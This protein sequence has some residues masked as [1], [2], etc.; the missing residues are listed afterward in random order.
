MTPPLS[1][2]ALCQALDVSRETEARLALYGEKLLTWNRAINLVSKGTL[3]DLWRRHFLDSG[4]LLDHFG[5][6][7]VGRGRVLVDLGS[8]AG[9]PGL[10]LAILGAGRVHLVEADQRKASFLREVVRLTEAPATIHACRIESL[11]PFQA[12]IVT[13]RACAPLTKLLAYAAP[14]C[15]AGDASSGRCFFLKGEKAEEE[16]TAA[17]KQW[18]MTVEGFP[19]RS[20]E[21]GVILSIGIENRESTRC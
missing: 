10:V 3:D 6:E 9:F 19:S 14:F 5:P 16:L 17:Q 11:A 2:E 4:Q 13:A 1:F 8:G 21:R 18:K 20:D 15:R 7:P 12:D